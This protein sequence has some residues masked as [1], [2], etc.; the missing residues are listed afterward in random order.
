MVAEQKPE[1]ITIDKW[2][3]RS[4][5]DIGGY[6]I[7]DVRG[8]FRGHALTEEAA[9]EWLKDA[10]GFNYRQLPEIKR[11]QIR[12]Q[13]GDWDK[14]PQGSSGLK[15]RHTFYYIGDKCL[16]SIQEKTLRRNLATEFFTLPYGKEYGIQGGGLQYLCQENGYRLVD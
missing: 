8:E 11:D 13:T 6:Y 10:S 5:K 16:G 4:A 15:F 3:A 14:C 9:I 12:S 2:T 1:T 7:H